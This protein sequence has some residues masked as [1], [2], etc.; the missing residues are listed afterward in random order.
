MHLLECDE[1]FVPPLS[2]RIDI[3]KY[4]KKLSEMSLTFEAWA[5]NI[6]TGLLAAYF[7][8]HLGFI[9]NV[10]V[11]NEYRGVGIASELIN[12]CIEYAKHNKIEEVRLIVH[13]DNHSAIKL[14]TKNGFRN[15]ADNGD[16]TLM[17]RMC[18]Q[19]SIRRA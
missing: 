7:E 13:K 11:I 17:H 16:E 4:S 1:F 5:D 6:L 15:L 8:N 2:R 18:P 19:P 10:S 14:Y 12:N 9:S 3:R